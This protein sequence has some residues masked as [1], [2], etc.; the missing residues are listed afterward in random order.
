MT[1]IDIIGRIIDNAVV[2]Y[3]FGPSCILKTR[4]CDFM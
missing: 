4:N 3:L 2:A 1:K